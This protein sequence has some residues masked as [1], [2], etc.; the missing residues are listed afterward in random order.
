M[1]HESGVE[2]EAITSPLAKARELVG[3]KYCTYLIGWGTL[4]R[5]GRGQG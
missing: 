3:V 5:H 2:L 1:G 4:R